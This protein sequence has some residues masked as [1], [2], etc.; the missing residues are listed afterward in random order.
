[1]SQKIKF[2]NDIAS[3]ISDLTG[4]IKSLKEISKGKL[5]R[6]IKKEMLKKIS[7]SQPNYDMVKKIINSL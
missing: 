7:Q 3:S 6:T 2:E 5:D 1:M 4:A